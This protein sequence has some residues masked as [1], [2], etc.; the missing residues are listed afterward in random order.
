MVAKAKSFESDTVP[1]DFGTLKTPCPKCGGEIH[2]NYKKFQCQKC[3]FSLWKIVAGRQLEIPEVEQLIEKGQ[4]GPLQG[5]RSAKGFPFAAIIK[6]GPEFKPEFDFGNDKKENGEDSAP[7]DFTGKE[8]MGKCPKCGGNVYDAGMNYLCENATG[9]SKKCTFKTGKIILQQ[10]M[11]P[12]QVRKMLAEGKTDLLKGFVSKKTNRKFEAFLVIKDGGTAFEF[13]PRE[14]KPRGAAKTT[15]SG[16]PVPKIDFTGKTPIGQCPKCNSKVFDTE[17]GY[18][19]ERSQA[20][21]RPCKFK[22]GK[23]I[24][25]QPVDADQAQK[26]IGTG[27]SDLLDKFISSKTGKP[28]KAYLVMDE[29]GKVTFDFPPREE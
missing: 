5:F 11:T 20:D 3:D 6:M 14:K 19:C 18:I 28:F 23:V 13:A 27:K 1:G 4:V 15:A 12:E 9:P 7:V 8:P 17:A 26:I 29:K 24:L 22:I 10:E 16:E 2:E 21:T 25:E